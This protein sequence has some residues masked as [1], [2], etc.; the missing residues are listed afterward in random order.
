MAP[1]I[2]Y[3]T[4]GVYWKELGLPMALGGEP[5]GSKTRRAKALQQQ[6]LSVRQIATEL[7]VRYEAAYSLLNKK[8]TTERQV[9]VSS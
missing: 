3:S 9:V 4:V 7:G 8:K 2:T 5:R 6:G 1:N